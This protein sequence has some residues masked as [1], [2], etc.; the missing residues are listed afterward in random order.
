MQP[1]PVILERI[2]D[3][4][5]QTVWEVLTNADALRKWF[6]DIPIFEARIGFEFEF[7]GKG[8]EGQ[9]F[10]HNC[11]VTGV[12][13]FKKLSYSWRYEGFEGISFVTY[14]LQPDTHGKAEC[15]TSY[16]DR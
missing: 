14:E 15:K 9:D 2:Y 7:R 12:E 8:K 16:R 5:V 3:A 13:P 11:V 4:P 10:L 1:H 6:F